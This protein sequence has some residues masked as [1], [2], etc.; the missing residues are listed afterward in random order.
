MKDIVLAATVFVP[1][2]WYGNRYR[3]IV[4]GFTTKGA[5]NKYKTRL[6]QLMKAMRYDMK[7]VSITADAPEK[8][9]EYTYCGAGPSLYYKTRTMTS[10]EMIAEL[11]TRTTRGY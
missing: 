9:V 3:Y 8:Y 11:E 4:T 1:D 5:A 10:D 7:G 2:N 6:K